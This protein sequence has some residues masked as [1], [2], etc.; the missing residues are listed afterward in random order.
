MIHRTH[1][2]AV[3]LAM[4]AAG[5]TACATAPASAADPAAAPAAAPPADVVTTIDP[6]LEQ[7]SGLS[8]IE[9]IRFEEM[10]T[11]LKEAADLVNGGE[12]PTFACVSVLVH[13]ES[14]SADALAGA[15]TKATEQCGREIPIAWADHQ[16]DA[17]AAT[18]DVTRSIGE[19]A[20]AMVSLDQVTK[21][22]QDP[23]VDQLRARAAELCS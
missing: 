3:L 14:D 23:R 21:R 7:P 12:N 13:A 11:N 2:I 1:G 9:K 19:C 10:S 20:T 16:L 6:T 18:G 15:A 17:V 8:R 22:F 4:L 5:L